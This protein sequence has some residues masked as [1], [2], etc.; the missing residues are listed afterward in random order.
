MISLRNSLIG[1]CLI[2]STLTLAATPT[3]AAPAKESKASQCKRFEQAVLSYGNSLSPK[4]LNAIKGKTYSDRMDQLL[5]KSEAS[6]KRLQ[7]HRFSDPKIQRYHQATLDITVAIHN[8]FVA[9][10]NAVETRDSAGINQVGSD[11]Q[12]MFNS[13]ELKQLD[14][15]MRSYCP[16]LNKAFKTK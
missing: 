13:P 5:A 16:N 11:F 1:L 15:A 10:V 3:Q 6:A 9:L 8:N 4:G 2:S 7:A 14:K 12:S